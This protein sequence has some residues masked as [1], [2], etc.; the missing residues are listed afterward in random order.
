MV[1]HPRLRGRKNGKRVH[2]I[3]YRHVIHA[4]RRKPQALA[5]SVYRDTLF[6]R[7]EYAEAWAWLS[8]TLPRTKAC[9]QMVA[10][11]A[12]AHDHNCE[13]DLAALITK[14]LATSEVPNAKTLRQQLAGPCTELPENRAVKLT[15]LS[16]FDTLP[17]NRA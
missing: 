13:A 4:L 1:S 12:L 10:L 9:R 2:C 3:N 7:S 17:E 6:P 8:E 5:S 14:A 15:D 16:R 11:L